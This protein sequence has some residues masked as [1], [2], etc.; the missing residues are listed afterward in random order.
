MVHKSSKAHP[1]EYASNTEILKLDSE[2][3]GRNWV[4]KLGQIALGAILTRRWSFDL[5][6]AAGRQP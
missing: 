5:S 1:K 4:D 2:K 6:E 3:L